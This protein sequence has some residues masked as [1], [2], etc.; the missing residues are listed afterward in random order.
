MYITLTQVAAKDSGKSHV[1]I[2]GTTKGL[3]NFLCR[4]LLSEGYAVTGFARSETPAEFQSNVLSGFYKHV[5]AD[6]CDLKNIEL[7][8][9][10]ILKQKSRYLI[11]NAADYSVLQ[12]VAQEKFQQQINLNLLFPALLIQKIISEKLKAQLKIVF[13]SSIIAEIYDAKSPMYGATKSAISHFIGGLQLQQ[14]PNVTFLKVTA[15]TMN[16]GEKQNSLLKQ[17]SSCS[18]AEAAAVIIRHLH[19]NHSEIFLPGLWRYII[20]LKKI[21]GKK[22]FSRIVNEYR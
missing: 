14:P 6:L 21:T 17:I 7:V 2:T 15:G 20:G 16:L 11:I 1:I 5:L 13:I 22:I 19:T 12:H 8:Y 4:Q 10:E 3:G 18:F 9:S